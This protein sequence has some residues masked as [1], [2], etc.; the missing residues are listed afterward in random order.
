MITSRQ[1]GMN[2]KGTWGLVDQW[3]DYAGQLDG[4]HAGIQI[5]SGPSNPPVWAHS[6]DYGVLVANPFPIDRKENREEK[7]WVQPG[8]SF[9]LHFGVQVH[10]HPTA[11]E[12]KAATAYARFLKRP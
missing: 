10:E 5:M 12:F 4:V 8:D 1:G 11:N 3:W 7:T 2:E 9:R 6:R